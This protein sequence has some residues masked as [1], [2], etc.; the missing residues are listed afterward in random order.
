MIY[1]GLAINLFSLVCK[2]F[3]ISATESSAL[4]LAL[5]LTKQKLYYNV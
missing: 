1:E 5:L 2:D 4:K 3:E